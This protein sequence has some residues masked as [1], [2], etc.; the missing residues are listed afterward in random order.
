MHGENLNKKNIPKFCTMI[1]HKITSEIKE[2]EQNQE[3]RK[4]NC[5]L[6]IR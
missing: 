3:S 5:T 2:K 1:C 6:A 4:G